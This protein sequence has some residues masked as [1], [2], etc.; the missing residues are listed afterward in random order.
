MYVIHIYIY[1]YSHTYTC[2][3]TYIY[4]YIT[5]C[6]HVTS[7]YAQAETALT[8]PSEVHRYGGLTTASTTYIS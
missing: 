1:I 8:A 3:Y 4:I 2:T 7:M 6:T 5:M